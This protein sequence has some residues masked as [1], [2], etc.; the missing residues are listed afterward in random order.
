MTKVTRLFDIPAYQL[1]N[2]DLPLAFVTKYNGTWKATTTKE[3]IQKA[4]A[5]S[6]FLIHKGVQTNDKVAIITNRSRTEWH[7]TDIAIMQIGAHSVPIYDSTSINDLNYIFDHAEVKHCFVANKDL[8]DKVQ[9]VKSKYLKNIFSFDTFNECIGI[10]EAIK[11]GDTYQNQ[12]LIDYIKLSIK[13]DDLATIIYTSGTTDKPKGVMLSHNNIISN[14][15]AC[16]PILPKFKDGEEVKTLSLLPVSHIFERMMLYLYQYNGYSIYFAESIDTVATDMS[17]VKPHIMTVVPRLLEKIHDKII[18]KGATLGAIKR[19][20]FNWALELGYK[21]EPYQQNGSSYERSLKRA[22]KLI[23]SKWKEV[24]GGNIRVIFCGSSKL[25]PRLARIFNAADIPIMDGYGLTETSPV[26]SVNSPNDYGMRIGSIGKPVNNVTIKIAQDGEIL[27]KGPNNM[28]GYYKN[29]M[30]TE[31]SFEDDYFKTGDLG[32]LDED[33]FLYITGRKKEAF[34]TSGGKYVNPSKIES[35]LKKSVFIEQ[36]MV[37]GEGEK[38]PAAIIQPN[39][40]LLKTTFSLELTN[41]LLI[42]NESVLTKI[43]SEIN[44]VNANLGQWEQIKRFELTE[45]VWSIEAGHLTPT[46]K[47]KK[48]IIKSKYYFLYNKIYRPSIF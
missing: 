44:L 29:D 28:L 15:N 7:I 32:E 16:L 21:Y 25:Q 9:Q 43:Q 47:V 14:L 42:K 46:L 1:E 36:I 23:F 33:G 37:I 3:Y 2:Y 8:F 13:P 38:M 35:E 31:S 41:D 12:A 18:A 48:D 26:I 34:K 22:R 45:D 20:L 39:F 30:K 24:F 6:R 17:V 27:S 11:K 4:N 5:L 40:E 10:E 19:K